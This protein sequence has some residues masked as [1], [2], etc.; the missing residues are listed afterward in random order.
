M[1]ETLDWALRYYEMGLTPI[2]VAHGTKKPL[3]EWK[4]YQ[5]ERPTREQIIE[6][7]NVKD[8]VNIATICGSVSNNFVAID[9]DDPEQYPRIFKKEEI[10]A[11][12]PVVRTHRGFQLYFRNNKPVDTFKIPE[13]SLEIR[14]NGAIVVMPPSLHPEGSQ[15]HYVNDFREPLTIDDIEGSIWRKIEELGIRKRVFT[16]PEWKPSKGIPYQGS[17]PPCVTGLLEGVQEGMRHEVTIRL[18]AYYINFRRSQPKQTMEKLKKW[19]KEKNQ[20]PLPEE[21]LTAILNDVRKEPY[22]YGCTDTIYRRFC[23]H[24]KCE[25]GKNKISEEAIAKAEELMKDP[26]AFIQHLHQCLEY[27]LTGEWK[28][29][30][31]VFLGAAGAS[32]KTCL[33]RIEGPNSVGKKML[34]YWLSEFFGEDKVATLSS[35]TAAWLKRKVLRGFDTRGKIFILIEERGDRQQSF[36][37]NFEQI[38]SEDKIKI[39]F[40]VRGESGDWEPIEVE[41]QGP[42]C[43]ITT[44]TELEQSF[45]AK[46]REWTIHPDES[47][48]QTQRIDKWSDWRELLPVARIEEETKEIEVIKAYLGLLKIHKD[49]RIPFIEAIDF[50]MRTVEDRRKKPDFMNFMRYACHLFQGV[51][52][53][54]EEYDIVFALPFVF[55]YVLAIADEMVFVSRGGLNN[56]EKRML[57]FIKEHPEIYALTEEGKR[58]RKFLKETRLGESWSEEKTEGFTIREVLDTGAFSDV[59]DNTI[60]NSLNGL[61]R[62]RRLKL[63]KG[64]RGGVPNVYGS[65]VGGSE[66]Q[67]KALIPEIKPFSTDFLN[68]QTYKI[69]YGD[70]SGSLIEGEDRL[71]HVESLMQNCKF[72]SYKINPESC[73]FQPKWHFSSFPNLQQ[74]LHKES[75]GE[76]EK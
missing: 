26:E 11:K 17:D 70:S 71:K 25:I 33:I 24:L 72:V 63:L 48:E 21:E 28:N 49:Y 40:N 45:H 1:K 73:L 15:Y 20:P 59:H 56:F 69:L 39:G 6:W 51:L 5:K 31:I 12:T 14:G 10:E 61:V 75:T 35:A 62:K 23:N 19:N 7:F 9:F 47:F 29:R 8:P 22:N 55:H 13:L 41:L 30:Q 32:V 52:P 18:A 4:K 44:S 60:R 64:S 37:Y 58:P 2:P 46:T 27:K 43:F 65:V 68:L 54:D 36:K 66:R 57:T 74:D 76:G 50:K 38:Y 3:V 53:V 42:L 67:E 16:S 34:Y